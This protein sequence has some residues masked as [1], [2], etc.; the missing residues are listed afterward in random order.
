MGTSKRGS[1]LPQTTMAHAEVRCHGN[2]PRRESFVPMEKRKGSRKDGGAGKGNSPVL[3]G[4]GIPQ[5]PHSSKPKPPN[6]PEG[7][8]WEK[9]T[10]CCG[11]P[12]SIYIDPA[13]LEWDRKG[14]CL[15]RGVDSGALKTNE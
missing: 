11:A 8:T 1:A 9:R 5:S 6:A 2:V 10:S 14:N 3:G 7:G 12:E 4:V 15:T 13:G